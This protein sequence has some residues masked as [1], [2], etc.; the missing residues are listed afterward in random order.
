MLYPAE[1]RARIPAGLA[2]RRGRV[3]RFRARGASARQ[4]SRACLAVAGALA[5]PAKAGAPGRTRTCDLR[6]RSPALYPTELR[7]HESPSYHPGRLAPSVPSAH[8][9]RADPPTTH[10]R[11]EPSHDRASSSVRRLVL[12]LAAPAFAQASRR[13]RPTESRT[14][15]SSFEEQV[16]VTASRGRAAAGQRAGGRQRSSPARRSRTRRPPTSATCCGP[17]PAST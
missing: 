12:A 4:P 13:R 7:A 2:T 17:C 10:A 14:S 16:V 11:G 8:N 6:I 5:R 1:L 9:E 15:R 3:I